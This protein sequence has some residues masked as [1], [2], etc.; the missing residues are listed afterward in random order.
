[1]SPNSI[2]NAHSYLAVCSQ[3]KWE[4]TKPKLDA[5][6]AKLQLTVRVHMPKMQNTGWW[7][8]KVV[9]KFH[10]SFEKKTVATTVQNNSVIQVNYWGVDCWSQ[11]ATVLNAKLTLNLDF[12]PSSYFFFKTLKNR[13]KPWNPQP[14]NACLQSITNLILHPMVLCTCNNEV[15]E[16]WPYRWHECCNTS[17]HTNTTVSSTVAIHIG[18]SCEE[19]NLGE[20]KRKT[21]ATVIS[22]MCPSSHTVTPHH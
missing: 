5:E 19:N 18:M 9:W 13:R 4:L 17:L 14:T 22:V 1:M 20:S 15:P 8:L 2:I 16:K 7:A 6:N 12:V 21:S 3:E 10:V 11:T